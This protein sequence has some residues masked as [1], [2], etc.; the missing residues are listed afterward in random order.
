MPSQPP[1][2]RIVSMKRRAFLAGLSG[3]S[4]LALGCGADLY[5]ERLQQTKDYF[6]YLE[7]VNQ[8]LGPKQ[9]PFEGIEIR[10]PKPFEQLL[11][12]PPPAEG[13]PEPPEPPPTEDP[14]RLGYHPNIRPEGLLATWKATVS[15]DAPGRSA[16]NAAAYLH[17]FSNLPRWVEK[18]TNA[19]IDPLTY[20]SDL[21]NVLANAY[22]VQADSS[23]APWPWDQ[24]RGFSPY[25]P[26]KRVDSIVIPPE[27]EP[28]TAV[29]YRFD[30]KDIQIG[31]LLI[32][33]RAIDTRLKLE[34]R[35]RHTLETLKVPN[36]PPQK[37]DSKPAGVGGF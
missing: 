4:W 9:T 19:D 5:N 23:D 29:L 28:I 13:E 35:M 32:Y 26:K 12:P 11:L 31:L 17:L 22:R 24:V 27:D 36:Q 37:K 7:R 16:A 33:P 6:E 18:Q 21:T 8:A 14:R 30:V 34:E 2:H 1:S 20:F 3:S 10:V 25:V 15:V